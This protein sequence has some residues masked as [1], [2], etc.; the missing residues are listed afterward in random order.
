MSQLRRRSEVKSD[1]NKSVSLS[2]PGITGRE[3]AYVGVHRAR[4][5][6]GGYRRA[7]RIT[8]GV[9][10]GKTHQGDY[11]SSWSAGIASEGCH[12]GHVSLASSNV[13]ESGLYKQMGQVM[14]KQE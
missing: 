13:D 1:W 12:K 6:A 10:V 11:G 9:E 2:Q 8:A 7:R 14:G 3:A 4:T 5:A